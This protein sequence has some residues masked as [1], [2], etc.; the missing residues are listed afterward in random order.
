MELRSREFDLFSFKLLNLDCNVEV[1]VG[2]VVVAV[3]VV[4]VVDPS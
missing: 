4:D 3:I 2:V 1:V